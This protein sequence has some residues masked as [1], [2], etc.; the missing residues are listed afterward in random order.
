V[1]WVEGMVIKK[2]HKGTVDAIELLCTELWWMN[3]ITNVS[4]PTELN[5]RE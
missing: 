2:W 1:E 3:D 5:A 4:K